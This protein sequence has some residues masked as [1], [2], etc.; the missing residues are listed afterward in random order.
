M[1]LA[2]RAMV[3]LMPTVYVAMTGDF[4]HHGHI[5][6]L[7][8]ARKLGDVT[9]GVLTDEAV[10][11]YKRVP[12]LTYEQR[13]RVIEN[14]QGVT[15]VVRQ[16]ELDYVPNLRKYK[17]DYVVH[18]DDWKQGVQRETRQRVIEALKEWN[19]KLI[20]PTYTENVSSTR[21]IDAF[22]KNG[23]TPQYRMN[24]LRRTLDVRPLA[25]VMEVHNGLT[26]LIVENT[27]V[28]RGAQ[29]VEFDAMWLSS[30][31]HSA[32]KGKPDIMF[33]DP[34]TIAN[35]VSEIFEIT[36]KPMIVD[37]DNGGL[38][39]HFALLVNR[40]ERLGVSAVIVEDK[41]G[42]KRNSLFGTDANQ[43][44]DS[45]EEFCRKIA[46]GKKALVTSDLM[47]IARVES[48]VLGAGQDDAMRRA[49]A[50]IEAGADGIMIHSSAKDPGE[51]MEFAKRFRTL[52]RRV[53]LVVVPSTYSSVLESEL[54][55][56]GVSIVIYA[57]H[58]L[59]SAYP[60]MVRA[61]RTILEHGRAAEA[62]KECTP[63]KDIIRLI[64]GSE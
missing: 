11:T 47:I 42:L 41:V 51:I 44:Q 61:A 57:N 52:D 26:G 23:T 58:L 49:H 22:F 19:G 6:V 14:L 25:R 53:P 38:A 45:I 55:Q 35:T 31:T 13:A 20:E 10:A 2:P 34:T 37:V 29:A 54:E 48:L 28:T 17:P 7:E 56:A 3:A 43:N 32:S 50:Y 60:A 12:I 40:L 1:A 8:T 15:K 36:T 4:I 62:D 59:R 24:R 9:V 30:L 46:T 5:N 18:G 64:P 33:V 27:K 39:E 21:I 63:I 16:T